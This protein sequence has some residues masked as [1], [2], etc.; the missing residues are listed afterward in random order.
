MRGN[1]DDYIKKWEKESGRHEGSVG[2]A[3]LDQRRQAVRNNFQQVSEA[4]RPSATPNK[5]VMAQL[6]EIERGLSIDLTPATVTGMKAAFGTAKANGARSSRGSPP[7]RS[8]WTL[9]APGF[10]RR[11]V[12]RPP[13]N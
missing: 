4:E 13:N 12:R 2:Q 5:P 8:N 3:T 6:D 10:H 7:C 1:V 11:G 9:S